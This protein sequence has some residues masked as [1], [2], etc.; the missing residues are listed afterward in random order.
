[1]R[2]IIPFL[3]LI[4][5][6]TNCQKDESALNDYELFGR[7][8]S[9]K[10]TWKVMKVETSSNDTQNSSMS[11]NEPENDFFHFYVLTT[12]IAGV[13][14]DIATVD[15][16][17]DGSFAGTYPVAA[18]TERVVFEGVSI[19]TGTVWTVVKNK[20]NRQVWERN[21]GS[22]TTRIYLSPCNC[23]FPIPSVETGG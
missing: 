11:T 2:Q 7:L 15:V 22:T 20:N 13:L 21:E 10:G 19:G 9:K 12:E 23:E 6:L 18:E 14:V 3:S 8:Q 17:V 4:F 1:M 5:I 16:Y